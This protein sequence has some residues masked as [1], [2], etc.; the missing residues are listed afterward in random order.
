[1]S[2]PAGDGPLLGSERYLEAIA[3]EVRLL[4]AAA[5]REPGAAVPHCPGWDVAEAAV[6]TGV[7]HRWV[8]AMVAARAS[9]ML[10]QSS[11]ERPGGSADLAGWLGEGMDRLAATLRAAGPEQPVWTLLGPGR[12]RFWFRR[13]AHETLVHRL[14][15]EDALGPASPV[16][17]QL[18]GDGVD[19]FLGV[20]LP[21]HQTRTTGEPRLA[22]TLHL[23][24]ADLGR[25]WLVELSSGTV[26]VTRDPLSVPDAE[27]LPGTA[28]GLLR[29]LWNRPE[30]GTGSAGAGGGPLVASWQR[31]VR[32]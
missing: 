11:V 24:A 2:V 8:T 31:I 21:L 1:M 15:A 25:S 23:V 4:A 9:E 5:A 30:P 19:E 17:P 26:E 22:G 14:D 20:A 27:T 28:L 12:S 7:R 16:D 6:H 3:G 10:D 29:F 18:A 13:M 32:V